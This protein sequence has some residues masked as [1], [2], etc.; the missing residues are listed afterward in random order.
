MN[1]TVWMT[2]LALVATGLAV[3]TLFRRLLAPAPGVDGKGFR[4]F[5]PDSYRPMER[6]LE[7]DDFRFLRAAPG[8]SPDLEKRLR[9]ERRAIFR[10]YLRRLRRDFVSLHRAARFAVAHGSQDR[11]DLAGAL[12]RQWALFWV[13]YSLVNLR[14]AFGLPAIPVGDLVEAATWM[15]RQGAYTTAGAVAAV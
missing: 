11:P 12:V 7:E 4:S 2:G 3:W 10:I 15:H 5:S 8:Y 1:L 9:A 6:L 13:A 14:L